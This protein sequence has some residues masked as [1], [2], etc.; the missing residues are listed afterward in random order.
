MGELPVAAM[1]RIIRNATG[2]RVGRDA[3]EYLAEYLDEIAS[4]IASE[5]GK[6]ARHAGRK[7][8]K[9]SD[10]KLAFRG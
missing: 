8:V 9:A 1:L 7:T 10:L 6:Y 3:G 4:E 2:M 5:A